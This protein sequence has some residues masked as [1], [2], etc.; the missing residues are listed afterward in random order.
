[1]TWPEVKDSTT[2]NSLLIIPIGSTE[3][4]GPHLPLGTDAYI[5]SGMAKIIAERMGGVIATPIIYGYYSQPKSGGGEL[6]PGTTGVSASTF[7]ALIHDIMVAFIRTGFRRIFILNSHYENTSILPEGVEKAIKESGAKDVCA[8]ILHWPIL[9]DKPLMDEIY[10]DSFPGWESEHAGLAETALMQ[11]LRP[12]L[13]RTEEISDD[14]AP[15]I[16]L[17]DVIPPPAD[18]ISKSGTMWKATYGSKEKG[19]F[20]VKALVEK[21]V[22][23]IQTELKYGSS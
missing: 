13:V 1:M 12:D 9:F 2:K 11:A 23:V 16:V 7:I 3:Q 21:I 17:Y 10:Q 15:R 19:E 20:L 8:V 18:I 4:H 14:R 6:F 5:A 22:K